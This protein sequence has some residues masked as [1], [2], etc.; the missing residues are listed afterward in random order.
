VDRKTKII[1]TIGP[2]TLD[3]AVFEKLIN[4]GVDFIRINSA[5]GDY[6][7]Y[8][9][10]LENFKKHALSRGVR[11]IYD[12]RDRSK[13]EYFISN[14]LDMIAVSFVNNAEQITAVKGKTNNAYTIAK[15]ETVEGAQNIDSI[16]DVSDGL[17]IARGDLAEAETIERVPVLQKEFSKKVIAKGKFLITATEM[18]LSMVNNPKPTIAEISD[19]SNAVFDGS[20]AVMLSEE[21]AIG[22]YPVEAVSY[23][24][25]AI[26]EAEKWLNQ[27]RLG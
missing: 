22:K 24:R 17:M 9:Q 14:K 20:N 25:R 7:Q 3:A 13:L 16:I 5:Y 10:I 21:T 11:V 8:D 26:I 18:L 23:M 1:V 2:A 6:K 4:E 15:I 27:G 19:V 12:I